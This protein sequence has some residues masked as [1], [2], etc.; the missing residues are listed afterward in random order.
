[1]ETKTQP[2]LTPAYRKRIGE[3]DLYYEDYPH[4]NPDAQ[5]L[6]LI[7]GFLSSTIS[8]RKLIPHLAEDYH[9]VAI[10]LPGF[11]KSEKSKTFTYS[12]ASYGKLV[13]S[14]IKEM[15]WRDVV[16][17]GH[18]MGGQVA[19]HASRQDGKLIRKLVLLGCCGY[20]KRARSTMICCSY[21]PFFSWG[22]KRWVLK[23]DLRNNLS[24]VFHNIDL[25][26][27]DMIKEYRA[28]FLEDGFFDSLIRLLRHRE[29]DL[30]PFELNSIVHPILLIHGNDDKVIPLTTGKRLHSDLKNSRLIVYKDAGHL[31]MEEKPLDLAR[32]I[33]QFISSEREALQTSV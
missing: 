5:V 23:K 26:T 21:L 10:D 13:L 30:K 2:L 25:V 16:L 1:M 32:D 11:G 14:F 12:L 33:K 24:G 22:L 6:I 18:S 4:R 3:L 15:G 20:I 17:I 8:F 7:H 29:G 31:I 19:L 9:V 27:E 28:Q